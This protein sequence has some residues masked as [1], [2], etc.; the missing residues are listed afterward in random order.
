MTDRTDAAQTGSPKILGPSLYLF[1]AL[2]ALSGV[3]C[4]YLRGWP[5]VVESLVGDLD[6]LI[7]VLPRVGAAVLIAGFLQALVPKEIVAGLLGEK[8]GLAGLALA[9]IAGA[10]TP[11]GPVTS[12]SIAVALAVAGAGRGPM[13]AYVTAWS[14]LGLQRILMWELPLLGPEFTLLRFAI[15]APLPII[16]GLLAQRIGLPIGRPPASGS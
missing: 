16:A 15:S 8:S 3:L 11:G 1:A 5:V 9:S 13:V 14:L 12:F 7:F 4:F 10:A 6:L 2:A